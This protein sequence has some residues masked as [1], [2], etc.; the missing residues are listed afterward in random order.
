MNERREPAGHY[1]LTLLARRDYSRQELVERLCRRGYSPAEAAEA[2]AALALSQALSDERYAAE[3]VRGRSAQGVG[4]VRIA[5]ELKAKGVASEIIAAALA[6]EE[7][8]WGERAAAAR[9]KRFGT[10]HPRDRREW[11]RQARFLQARGFRH[12]DI[13]RA[14]DT[15]QD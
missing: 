3:R 9:A 10:S 8:A 2:A 14:M 4:P 15:P 12:E 5:V 1:G 7:G 6:A 11:A 13:M